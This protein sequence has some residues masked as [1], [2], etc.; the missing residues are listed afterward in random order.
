MGWYGMVW[1]GLS[2][3]ECG[4]S[5]GRSHSVWRFMEGTWVRDED[6]MGWD[7]TGWYGM[8]NGWMNCKNKGKT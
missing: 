1:Y 7:R 2:C 8:M 4:R 3:F 5:V 6:G